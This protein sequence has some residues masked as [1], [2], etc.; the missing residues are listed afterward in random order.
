MV[1][2]NTTKIKISECLVIKVVQPNDINHDYISTLNDKK[3]VSLMGRNNDIM[4]D[5]SSIRSYIREQLESEK[6]SLFGLFYNGYLVSTSRVHGVENGNAWQG[7]LVFQACQKKGYGQL[8]V[9]EVSNYLM[10][11]L[12][13][14]NIYAG[15]LKNNVKS[16]NLFMKCGFKFVKTDPNYFGREVWAK[17]NVKYP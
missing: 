2:S 13:I 12:T 1:I 16:I 5:E 8:I 3:Y 4:H 15:I 17:S 6:S 10:S 14:N 11:H 9:K 7:I